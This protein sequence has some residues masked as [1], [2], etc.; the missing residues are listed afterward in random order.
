MIDVSSRLKTDL[1]NVFNNLMTFDRMQA[2]NGTI[3]KMGHYLVMEHC[4][5]RQF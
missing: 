2:L 4:L 5:I 1:S 3:D